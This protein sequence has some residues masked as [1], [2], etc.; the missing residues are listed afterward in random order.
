MAA[1]PPSQARRAPPV[2]TT[3]SSHDPPAAA[4]AARTRCSGGSAAHHGRVGANANSGLVNR[5]GAGEQSRCLKGSGETA[6]LYAVKLK[7][8]FESQVKP[9]F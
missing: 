4:L 1:F 8:L 6:P 2:G 9:P 5:I 3:T 7:C